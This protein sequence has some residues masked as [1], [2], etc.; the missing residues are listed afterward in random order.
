M[1]IHSPVLQTG[2]DRIVVSYLLCCG[3]TDALKRAAEICVEQ[4][5]EFPE[6]LVDHGDIRKKSDW[7]DRSMQHTG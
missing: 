3:Y 2:G 6:D 5:I 7:A 4:T 1:T